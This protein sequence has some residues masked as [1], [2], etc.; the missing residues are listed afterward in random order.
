MADKTPLDQLRLAAL[1]AGC[2]AILVDGRGKIL[3]INPAA[4]RMLAIDAKAATG[5]HLSLVMPQTRVM[6]TLLTGKPVEQQLQLGEALQVTVSYRPL[7][8]AGIVNGAV[9]LCH[10]T[11]NP[12]QEGEQTRCL[13]ML[14]DI[15]EAILADIP[16][17]IVVVDRAGQVVMMNATYGNIL[18]IDPSTVVGQPISKVAGFSRLPEVIQAG[19][20]RL[21]RRE[22]VNQQE[23][24]VTEEPL[25]NAGVPIGGISKIMPVEGYRTRDLLRMFELLESKL[26]FYK[27]EIKSYWT[28]KSPFSEIVGENLQFIK[29]KRLGDK[30]ARGDASILLV[31][32]SGT[33]KE[34]FAH[35][36]HHASSRSA[37]PFVKLNCAAIPENLL[38]A[39]LFGY[40]E[41]AF[42]GAAKGGRAG[43]FELA[44]GGTIFLDEIGD[45]PFSMQA[46]ILRVLQ[47]RTFERVG[48]QT[49]I[50]VDVRI[51][52]ATNQDLQELVRQQKFRLDLYY[53]LS[54]IT[55]EL[56]PLRDRRDDIPL[57]VQKI[58]ADMNAKYRLNIKRVSA[59][60]QAML[61]HYSWP[62]NVRQLQNVLEYAFNLAE[63][64]EEEITV[65]HLPPA[66]LREGAPDRSMDLEEVMARAEREALIRA[67]QATGGNKQ[68]AANLLGIHRSAFYQKLKKYGLK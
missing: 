13:Q 53:R 19:T 61:V 58:I 55:L 35:A 57:L 54:V 40:E 4:A 51:I 41:G 44:H 26:I 2:A 7:P 11:V 56:P 3:D 60:V 21:A 20:A 28:N 52:A 29:I 17:G 68:N 6:E 65:E 15:Y 47:D 45:M 18:A 34:L 38:E 25:N 46:K 42:T 9:A 10:P 62:G 67:L 5:Q 37:E 23:I 64:G 36:I 24:I 30:V 16:I 27:E 33:G 39:E 50:C 31:G 59:D 12:P 1:S 32:E 49:P 22:T 14:V 48:G 43:K 63:Y 8:L 66:F